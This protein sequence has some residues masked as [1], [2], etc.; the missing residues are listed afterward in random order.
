MAWAVSELVPLTRPLVG[1]LGEQKRPYLQTLLLLATGPPAAIMDPAVLMA[2]LE[3]I[4][5]WVLDP[6]YSQGEE[7]PLT[8]PLRARQG[9]AAAERNGRA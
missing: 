7:L 9:E 3:S 8:A 5:L 2:V 1:S 6:A 4:K